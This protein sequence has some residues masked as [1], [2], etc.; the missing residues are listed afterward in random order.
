MKQKLLTIVKG[1][2]VQ[3]C[4]HWDADGITSA[5]IIYHLIKKDAKS[6]TTKT[7][8]MPFLITKEDI[9]KEIEV[10]I[11]TDIHPSVDILEMENHPKVI[12]IDHHPC[13]NKDK[14]TLTIHDENSKS[15]SLLIYNTLLRGTK[16]P[17]MIFLVLLGYFG[18]GG[19]RE[20]IPAGLLKDAETLIPEMM[21][22]HESL[23]HDGFY[24]EIEK[25]V[26]SLNTG[27]RMNWSGDLPLELL[28][29]IDSCEPYVYGLHPI[30]VQLRQYRHELKGSY[31]A[32]VEVK[33]TGKIDYIIIEDPKNVQ[34]VLAAKHIKDR[35]IMVIN[36]LEEDA[37]GSMRCPENLDFDVGKFLSNFSDKIEGYLGGGHKSAGGFT[38]SKKE[39]KV[40]MELVKSSEFNMLD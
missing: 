22:K 38:L 25:Y 35:P 2:K 9:G 26:S 39:L 19:D 24:Y 17:Y 6:I 7:K 20:Q 11:C 37:I 3:L 1:K 8:G 34:G 30:A 21:E 4:T 5:A 14:F 32:P 13:D 27:K 18:D 36:L 10:V 29:S 40:F 31:N 15:A 12:Y 28:K 33:S 23:F 16:D